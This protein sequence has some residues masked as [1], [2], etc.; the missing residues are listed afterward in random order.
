[1]MINLI[2]TLLVLSAIIISLLVI[3]SLILW[4]KG[5]DAVA[6]SGLGIIVAT[7]LFTVSL[8]VLPFILIIAA[9][10][11]SRYRTDVSTMVGI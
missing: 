5:A 3:G 10:F 7:S 2:F 11:F 1:M 9:I 6:F 4:L 8:T